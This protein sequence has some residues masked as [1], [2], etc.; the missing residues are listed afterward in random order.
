MSI[1]GQLEDLIL[2][3]SQF[4]NLALHLADPVVVIC[5]VGVKQVC[6]VSSGSVGSKVVGLFACCPI[7]ALS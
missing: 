5:D 7:L 6:H 2:V 3:V 1:L 4:L